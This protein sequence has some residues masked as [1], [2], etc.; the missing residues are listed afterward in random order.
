[1]SVEQKIKELLE[2]STIVTGQEATANVQKDTSK[3]GIAATQ[4]DSSMPM[5]GSSQVPEID[6]LDEPIPGQQASARVQKDNTLPTQKGDAAS[7]KTQ[8]NE[9]VENID[10]ISKETL[11]NYINKAAHN[12]SL[13][14]FRQGKALGNA[15]KY[16]KNPDKEEADTQAKIDLKREKGISMA[17]K[18][19]T[20]EDID[21]IFGETLTEEQQ[22]HASEIFEAAVIARVNEEMIDIQEQLEESFEISLQEQKDV[23]VEKIDSFLN[24]VVEQWIEENKLEVQQGIKQDV[25]ENFIAGMKK[26]FEESY[27]DIPEDKVDLV[28]SLQE[29]VEDLTDMLN[30]EISKSAEM[31]KTINESRK[32]KIF[33]SVAKD[34]VLTDAEK[35]EKLVEGIEFTSDEIYEEKLKMVKHTHFKLN[36]NVNSEIDTGSDIVMNND[37]MSRY[38]QVISKSVKK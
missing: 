15:G 25:T 30:E 6:E 33:E 7:V 20:K 37:R 23:M 36:E 32:Q 11:G 24:Y 28:A 16:H 2:A 35:F 3:A 22:N 18:K 21:N 17:V 12:K 8:A 14:A 19:L 9:S 26:L 34:L 5:Q 1:M 31:M 10:E 13:A 27:I 4:G 38:V 29:K